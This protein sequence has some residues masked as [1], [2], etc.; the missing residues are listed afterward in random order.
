VQDCRQVAQD[1]DAIRV[2]PWE[3]VSNKRY[4]VRERAVMHDAPQ[5]VVDVLSVTRL[6]TEEVG[7]FAFDTSFAVNLQPILLDVEASQLDDLGSI[8]NDQLDVLVGLAQDGQGQRANAS[9]NVTDLGSQRSV[10]N[11]KDD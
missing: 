9:A 3:G 2:R 1:L 7:R 10:K 4:R 5:Y 8:L 6:S 11:E